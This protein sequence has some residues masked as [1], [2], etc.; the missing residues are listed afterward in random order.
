MPNTWFNF[1]GS[2]SLWLATVSGRG[3]ECVHVLIWKTFFLPLLNSLKPHTLSAIL[4]LHGGSLKAA[5]QQPVGKIAQMWWSQMTRLLLQEVSHDI[6]ADVY[7][8]AIHRSAGGMKTGVEKEKWRDNKKRGGTVTKEDKTNR[9]VIIT[10]W[11][12]WSAI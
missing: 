10:F 12:H 6:L 8:A 9:E 7:G 2:V 3:Y 1:T 4:G 5:E 11:D